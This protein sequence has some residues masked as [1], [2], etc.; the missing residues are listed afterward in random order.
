MAAKI[1]AIR[2]DLTAEQISRIMPKIMD[3]TA[4]AD[5]GRPGM[6]LAQVL[7]DRMCVFFI[8]CDTAMQFQALLGQRVGLTTDDMAHSF[9]AVGTA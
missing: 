8:T 2:V 3:A 9:G 7:G 5:A 4:A 1:S 6:V